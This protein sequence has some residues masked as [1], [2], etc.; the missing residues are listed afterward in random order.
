MLN[1][2]AEAKQNLIL[3]QKKTMELG[4]KMEIKKKLNDQ[5]MA[6]IIIIPILIIMI[7]FIFSLYS[8]LFAQNDQDSELFL[9]MPDS[10]Y[11][12]CVKET[13]YMRHHHWEL[14][15]AVREDVVRH[16]KRG[17]IYLRRYG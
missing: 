7:P 10:K 8:F 15:R 13:E 11:K 1:L 5:T 14:L 9:E 17:E 4:A 6:A 3:W 12:N 16:G 2:A